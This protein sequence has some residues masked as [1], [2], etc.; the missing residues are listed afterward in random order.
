MELVRS[1]D[2]CHRTTGLLARVP[3]SLLAWNSHYLSFVMWATAKL[4][5]LEGNTVV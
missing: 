1:R 2:L 4:R 5:V 3:L